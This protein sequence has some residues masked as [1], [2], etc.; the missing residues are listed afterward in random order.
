MFSLRASQTELHCSRCNNL[1]HSETNLLRSLV[2]NLEQKAVRRFEFN[3]IR[4]GYAS[5]L[6]TNVASIAGVHACDEGL[7]NCQ[8][9]L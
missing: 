6:V 2:P 7:I 8:E 5:H 1:G 9:T 3:D 4:Y